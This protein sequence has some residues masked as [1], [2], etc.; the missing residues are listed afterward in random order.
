MFKSY[1][2]SEARAEYHKKQKDPKNGCEFCEYYKNGSALFATKLSFGVVNTYPYSTGHIM[3]LPIRH[4]KDVRE[5]ADEELKDM[6]DCGKKLLDLIEKVYHMHSFNMGM[7]IGQG[8]GGSVEHLHL[9]IVPR[10]V[11]DSGFLESTSST[12][13]LKESP[14]DTV[15]KLKKAIQDLGGF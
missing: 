6:M 13:I 2:V 5:L 4:V 10:A 8:S 1:L 11:G 9:H 3:V 12:R 15:K 14:Q 7:N